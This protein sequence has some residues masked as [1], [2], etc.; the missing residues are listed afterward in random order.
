[1]RQRDPDPCTIWST[2]DTNGTKK[3]LKYYLGVGLWNVKMS[4]SEDL[5]F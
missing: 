3:Y 4:E 2:Q 5:E 1:M